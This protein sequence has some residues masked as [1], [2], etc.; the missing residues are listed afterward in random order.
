[1]TKKIYGLLVG[2]NNY[3]P[4][5]EISSLN[6]CVN[7]IEAIKKYLKNAVETKN[8]A[9][10]AKNK[11][12]NETEE[13][14]ELEK[15]EL[16]KWELIIKELTNQSAT[17]QG[18]ID[19]FE[20]HL[21]NAD[22]DDVVLFYY[23]GHGSYEPVPEVFRHIEQDGKLETLV[24]Y[25]SRTCDGKNNKVRD[26]AD[27]EL[28]YLIERVAEK[29][30]HILIILDSCH[31]GTATRDPAVVERR[32]HPSTQQPRDLKDFIFPKEW[33]NR[34]VRDDY[35]RP[36]H[37]AISACRDF[38]TAKEHT[39]ADGQPRGAFSYFLTESLQR[40]NGGL[41]YANLVQDINALITSKFKEQSPQ[42]EAEPKDSLI[43]T[44]L[45]G[46][47]GEPINYFTLTYDRKT[48]RSWTIDGG[49]LHGIRPISKGKNSKGKNSEGKNS[50]GKTSLAI[51]PQGTK[52]ED[53]Q[54]IDKAICHAEVT[55]VMTGTSTVKLLEEK[56]ELSPETPYWAVIS[57][58]PLPNLKVF[59]T[60][61]ETGKNIV[62]QVFESSDNKFVAK[63]D[64]EEN[65]DYY[66]EADKGQYWIVQ[67]GDR[68]PL[69]APVPELSDKQGYT[70]QRAKQIIKRLEHIARWKN[71]LELKTPATSQIKTSDVEMEVIVTSGDEKYSSS[72]DGISPFTW[73]LYL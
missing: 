32:T 72:K 12:K 4:Q 68:K 64:A 13:K 17:R 45:G 67:P 38:Q 5:S 1:M 66:L 48:H 52:L 54:D 55:Q 6:G 43:Q 69:V 29:D 73:R 65:A 31:S 35:Q 28:N 41:S 39:D 40:T 44:F 37:I 61:D 19:G 9:I 30:P 18:I 47:A 14:W 58:V 63:A 51:F 15:W 56:I 34:R 46:A 49:T 2:I 26:L 10:K 24:C 20:Q 60:G 57:D 3:H 50:E 11:K 7:D 25:D 16:E 71:I 70:Q 62:L 53:L 42:I 33:V 59:F 27:K 8:N 23:A 22:S 21:C 36:R